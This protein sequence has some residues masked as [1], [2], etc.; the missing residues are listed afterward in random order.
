MVPGPSKNG[1]NPCDKL[2]WVERL[3]QVIVCPH[4]KTHDAVHIL[5][6]CREHQDGYSDMRT[7]PLKDLKTVYARKHDIQHYQGVFAGQGLLQT[8]LTIVDG[9]NLKSFRPQILGQ[10]LA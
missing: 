10:E 7:D 8:F 9:E 5:P 4:L 3:G 1:P 2:A 6:A